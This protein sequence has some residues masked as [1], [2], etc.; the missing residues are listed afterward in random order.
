MVELGV[1]NSRMKDFYDISKACELDRFR[2]LDVNIK[3]RLFETVLMERMQANKRFFNSRNS[4][5]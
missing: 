5:A 1:L 2:T 4:R 3:L